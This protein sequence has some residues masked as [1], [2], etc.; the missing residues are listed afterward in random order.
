MSSS[1]RILVCSSAVLTSDG[2]ISNVGDEALT[3]VLANAVATRTGACTHATLHLL[4][5]PNTRLPEGRVPVRPL[6]AL[7]REIYASDLVIAGGGTLLQEDVEPRVFEPTA[8]LLRY[9]GAVACLARL[10]RKPFMLAGIGAEQLDSAKARRAARFIC[11]SAAAITVRDSASAALIKRVSG[12]DALIAADPMFLEYQEVDAGGGDEVFVNLRAGAP[13]RLCHGLATALR[14]LVDAGAQVTLV[15]M[16]R[17]DGPA[18][19][20]QVLETFAQALDRP[21]STRFVEPRLDWRELLLRFRK[22]RLCVGMRLHFMIFASLAARPVVAVTSLPKTRS[23]VD[24]LGLCAVPADA[25]QQ[26]PEALQSAHAPDP[27]R[28]R[29]LA[30]RAER[31]LDCAETLYA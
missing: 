20:K 16:D 22:A 6:R 4:G 10:Y 2:D 30:T 13:A 7:A 29:A 28:M 14:P 31:T 17:R 26:F 12:E 24:E 21:G 1:S 9:V 18:G 23:F 11:R 3:Q 8:G 25:I 5:Q 19:D 27:F 15:P